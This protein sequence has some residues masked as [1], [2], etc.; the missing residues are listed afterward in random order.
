MRPGL[1]ENFRIWQFL[2]IRVSLCDPPF[3][4]ILIISFPGSP[5]KNIPNL[6]KPPYPALQA[7]HFCSS[8]LG[9]T[10]VSTRNHRNWWNIGI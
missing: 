4:I 8:K 7:S 6:G 2:K 1:E 3:T 5:P 9:E 10:K